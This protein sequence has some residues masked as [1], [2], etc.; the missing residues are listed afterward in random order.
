MNQTGRDRNT[1]LLAAAIF[2]AFAFFG[3]SDSAR[4]PAIPRFQADFGVTELQIGLLLTFNTVGYVVA[5][6]YTAALARKIGMKTCMVGAL[7]LTLAAG[8]LIC[9]APN[10]YVLMTAFFILNLGYGTMEISMGVISATIFTK[11]TG[12][13]LNLAHFF[14]GAGAV[15]SPMV[16]TRLMAMRFGGQILGWRY[17]Y[18]IVFG[19][20][21]AP[22]IPAIIG[23][24][25]KQDYNKKKTGYRALL[26]KPAIWLIMLTVSFS[27]ICEMGTIA[28][29]VNFFEKA[30][31][32][33][34]DRAALQLTL[35]FVYFTLARLVLGPAIDKIGYINSIIIMTAF[36]GVAIFVGVLGGLT[37]APLLAI[38]GAGIG[39]VW[40]TIMAVIAKLFYDEIDLAMTA[41]TTIMGIIIIP[42]NLVLGAI[43]NTARKIFAGTYGESGLR[44]AYSAGYLFVGLCAFGACTFAL[45]LRKR[46]KKAGQLV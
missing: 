15:F 37:A 42:A 45:L 36:T 6:S 29:I 35:F 4:G 26:K 40:P 20:A 38:A 27:A 41:V 24:L 30:W 3:F 33:P 7:L 21:L 9:F 17:M 14:Y 19:F 12:A 25:K 43:I 22:V 1:I 44:L 32:F 23:R 31:S 11:N 18:L 8:V 13:M 16:T 46:Q 5:C 10:Y 2:I 28:W 39:P 34:A